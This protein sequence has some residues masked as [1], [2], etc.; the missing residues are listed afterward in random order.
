MLLQLNP[1][2]R[3]YVEGK[4][5]GT[6]ILVIDYGPDFDLLFTLIMDDTGEVWTERNPNLRGVENL[7]MGRTK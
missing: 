2:L 3:L 1:P 6:A 5:V 4:G 7:T